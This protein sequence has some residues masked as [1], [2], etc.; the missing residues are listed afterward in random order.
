MNLLAELV[1]LSLSTILVNNFVLVKFL[2]ALPV[3]RR[4]EKGEHCGR[5][6]PGSHICHDGGVG[7]YV[8]GTGISA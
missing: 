3:F 5:H 2:G 7:V 4:V 8:A 1:L 6:E